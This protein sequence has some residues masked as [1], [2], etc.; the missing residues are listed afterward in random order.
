ME[1][2]CFQIQKKTELW[3]SVEYSSFSVG[4]EADKY[5][6]SVSGYSGDAGD[7]I[8]AT[9]HP[10][11]ICNGMQFST[12]DQD[13]DNSRGQCDGGI[14]GWWYNW[15]GRSV[16]N[17][18]GKAAWNAENDESGKDVISSRMLVKLA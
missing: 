6:L 5:R 4:P 15:C 8:A 17:R 16:L 14:C 3:Y 18:V 7:A 11:R 12:P 2:M 13:N 1:S 9:V 10:A